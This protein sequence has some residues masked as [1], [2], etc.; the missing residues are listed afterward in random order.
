MEL[1]ERKLCTAKEFGE[2]GFYNSHRNLK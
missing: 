2:M 1:S